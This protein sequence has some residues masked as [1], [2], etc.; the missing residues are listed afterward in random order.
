M[1][2]LTEPET[3]ARLR[4]STSKIKRLR[5]SGALPYIPGRP[6]LIDE[7]DLNAYLECLKCRPQNSQKQT[8]GTSTPS[9]R[10]MGD[11]DARAWARKTV[12]LQKAG[13]RNGS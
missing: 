1:P 2:F 10:T 11:P 13:S 5:L 9:G 7:T 12:L 8:T 6:V 4:C 3:A